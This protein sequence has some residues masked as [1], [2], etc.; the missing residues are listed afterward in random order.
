MGGRARRIITDFVKRHGGSYVLDT[1]NED[2]AWVGEDIYAT[3]LKVDSDGLVLV[4]NSGHNSEYLSRMDDYNVLDLA[5][6]LN[7]LDE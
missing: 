2:L 1:E 4:S 3:A 7:N 5:N 6:V